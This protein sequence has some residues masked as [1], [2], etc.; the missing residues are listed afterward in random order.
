MRL[1]PRNR[2]ISGHG[3][4]HVDSTAINLSGDPLGRLKS[5]ER[6][7]AREDGQGTGAGLTTPIILT[8]SKCSWLYA[9]IE[10]RIGL[11]RADLA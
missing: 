6:E 7:A 11:G 2:K 5:R 4:E 8:I 3:R 1:D 9:S 10:I